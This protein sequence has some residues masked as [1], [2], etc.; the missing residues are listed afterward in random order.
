MTQQTL[1][2]NS[3]NS[4]IH[5]LCCNWVGRN[6]YGQLSYFG[7]INTEREDDENKQMD[8]DSGNQQISNVPNVEEIRFPVPAQALSSSVYFSLA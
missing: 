6:E 4:P 8:V 7:F 2:E 5:D 3:L 1:F